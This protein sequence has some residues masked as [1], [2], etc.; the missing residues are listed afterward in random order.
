MRQLLPA[1]SAEAAACAEAQGRSLAEVERELFFG[2][3]YAE[4]G[5]LLLRKW[6]I[7]S[8]LQECVAHQNEPQKAE[9]FSFEAAIVHCATVVSAAFGSGEKPAE[10][11]ERMTP[12]AIRQTGINEAKIELIEARIMEHLADTLA[13]LVPGMR[14]AS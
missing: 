7:P 8:M 13:V 2:F 5:G 4:V 3:D 1:Q 10:A 11:L 6:R 12:F 14:M 9:R